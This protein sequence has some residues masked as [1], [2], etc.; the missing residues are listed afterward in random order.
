MNKVRVKMET[1]EAEIA[2]LKSD[3][4]GLKAEKSVSATAKVPAAKLHAE[5]RARAGTVTY[6]EGEQ[7]Q[8]II[9]T[10][11]HN[12]SALSAENMHLQKECTRLLSRRPTGMHDRVLSM[13][14]SEMDDLR[15]QEII[16]LK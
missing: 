14:A 5:P 9:S 10:L 8:K 6:R 13:T 2:R 16:K 4:E 12:L 3:N 15:M 7:M 1:L 11:N